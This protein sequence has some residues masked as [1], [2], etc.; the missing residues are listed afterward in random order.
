MFGSV[1]LHTSPVGGNFQHRWGSF[2]LVS[3]CCLL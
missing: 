1:H 2:S 3:S